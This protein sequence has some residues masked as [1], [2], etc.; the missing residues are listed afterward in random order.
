MRKNH[1]TVT[2]IKCMI[3]QKN[4]ECCAMPFF[5]R[6]AT[7]AETNKLIRQ[8]DSDVHFQMP[9]LITVI[10]KNFSQRFNYAIVTCCCTFLLEMMTD[11]WLMFRW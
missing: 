11:L 9:Q 6:T 7:A 3:F 1:T 8:N 5:R 2:P 4:L 10:F